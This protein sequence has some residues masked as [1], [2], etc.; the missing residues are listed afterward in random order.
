MNWLSLILG[1]TP[2]IVQGVQTVIGDKA[3]GATKQQMAKDAL[4]VAI[5]GAGATLTGNNAVLGDAAGKIAGLVIDQSVAIAK[6][7]GSYNKW[8][9]IATTAQ[10]DLG[11]AAAVTQLVQSLQAPTVAPVPTP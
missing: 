6:A 3:A 4:G 5:G 1:L 11:V 2:Y 9:T 10:Q 8:T 7:N